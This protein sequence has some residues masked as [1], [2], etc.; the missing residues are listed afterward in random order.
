MWLDELLTKQKVVVCVGSG[1]VG[2][3]TTAA[4]IGVRAAMN[5]QK[6]LCLTIDPAK[7]LANSLGLQSMGTE[8]QTI[9]KAVFEH[10]NLSCRG[11]LSA[12][13]LDT[14]RTFDELVHRYAPST[15][16]RERILNNRIYQYVST[17]LAGTS[18]Y[19][20]MEKLHAVR[21]TGD[22]DLI[23]LDTPPTSNALDFL[24]APERLA[25]LLD[26]PALRWFVQAFESTG[27]L[28]M[29]L[30]GKGAAF[31]LRGLAKF[32]GAEFLDQV[33]EFVTDLND[34]F[35]G[36]RDRATKISDTLRKPEVA[37][38]VVTTPSPLALDEALF[39]HRRL[40]SIDMPASAFVVNAVHE[41]LEEPELP[42]PELEK[43]LVPH[44]GQGQEAKPLLRKLRRA[45]DDERGRALVDRSQLARL[46][47]EVGSSATVLVVPAFE[48]DVHDLSALAK[49]SGFLT[50]SAA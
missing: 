14:K 28:S 24:D 3:T 11:S 48:T 33:A 18:E 36:F 35:G 47:K 4:A 46:R 34:M 21:E 49:V 25:G 15:E 6:V 19:M 39:L 41:V 42:T 17:S 45:L 10:H 12:M 32:T 13:M 16:V 43:A 31:L 20:A 5:G 26:S 30:M 2:K 22:W 8:E 50:G 44:L 27:K 23:V 1:G 7:R 38:L 29:N 9:D 40:L 37:F